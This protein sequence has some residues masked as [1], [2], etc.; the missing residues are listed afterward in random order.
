M[1]YRTRYTI[2]YTVEQK[3]THDAIQFSRGFRGD[4]LGRS[5]QSPQQQHLAPP[6]APAAAPR[7]EQSRI[8]PSPVMLSCLAFTSSFKRVCLV[9]QNHTRH[10]QVHG[11]FAVMAV[12]S[13][14]CASGDG[15]RRAWQG[16]APSN[17]LATRRV[18]QS[19]GRTCN[20]AW[21]ANRKS[22]SFIVLHSAAR[23]R[24]RK[25]IQAE[26]GGNCVS[27]SR[28]FLHCAIVGF[29]GVCR[30]SQLRTSKGKVFLSLPS[31]P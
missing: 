29:C 31:V 5:Q 13:H 21:G 2:K 14:V 8:S 10:I 3:S 24:R 28:V 9:N 19:H 26:V 7:A 16:L 20:G 6:T 1:L 4:C 18:L 27:V 15:M 11:M 25:G 12:K 17:T 22:G 23:R 30:V